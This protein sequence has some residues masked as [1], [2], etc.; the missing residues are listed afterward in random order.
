MKKGRYERIPPVVFRKR[1]L[2]VVLSLMLLIIIG[3]GATLAYFASAS[4]PVINTFQAGSVGAKIHEK[5]SS[6]TKTSI[7]VE[8]TGDSPVYVRVRLISYWKK[9][10]DIAPKSSALSVSENANKWKKIGEYY[11]Y[12]APLAGGATTENL[13]S[14]GISMTT[15][16][17]Y[18]Q[19]VE[20]L[21]DTV[22]ASPADAVKE[23]WSID[24]A[25]FIG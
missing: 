15:E 6:N 13:L 9:G 8:N 5:I 18:T 3:V 25:E 19:V 11:Y 7:T 14:S 24:A 23:V 17:G 2:A 21:V 1:I 4:G 10:S 20:V 16:D 22:Q 12:T